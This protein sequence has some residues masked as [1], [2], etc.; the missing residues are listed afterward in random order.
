[1]ILGGN[2]SLI[3][4]KNNFITPAPVPFVAYP[5]PGFFPGPL[6]FGRWSFSI[7]NADFSLT[8]ISMPNDA[9]KKYY[10]NIKTGRF[11]TKELSPPPLPQPVDFEKILDKL[12]DEEYFDIMQ[13]LKGKKTV[14]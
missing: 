4:S 7:Q 6:V 9:I 10:D 1:M 3:R 14:H 11:P 12:Q 13:H 5:S 8:T 2:S